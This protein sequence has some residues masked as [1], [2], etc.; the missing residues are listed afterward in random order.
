VP[1]Q[2]YPHA[3]ELF[4]TGQLDWRAGVVRALLLPSVYVAN[5]TNQFLS[6]IPAGSRIAVSENI[7]S[8][9][10]VSGLCNGE[11]AKFPLLF[12]NRAVSQLVFFK[13]TLIE[14]TSILIAYFAQDTLIN[15]PFVPVGF[16]YYVYPNAAEGGY[17]RI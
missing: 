8:R 6:D 9:T 11:P 15:E 10:A 5:F 7:D 14:T 16:D 12:D 1:S 2:L 3:R 4:A 13:D 17:F